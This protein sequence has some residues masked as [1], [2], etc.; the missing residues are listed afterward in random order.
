[1]AQA[2]LDIDMLNQE[3]L[4]LSVGQKQRV[5]LIRALLLHPAVLMLDEPTSALSVRETNKVLAI[6]REIADGG[7]SCVFVTHNLYQAFNLCDRFVVM[8]HGALVRTMI[9]KDTSLEELTDLIMTS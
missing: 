4:E 6:M 9:K 7:N 5:C 3:A 2:G 8:A 1:M